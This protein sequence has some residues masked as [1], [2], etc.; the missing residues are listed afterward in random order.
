MLWFSELFVST[1]LQWRSNGPTATRNLFWLLDCQVYGKAS[2]LSFPSWVD[3]FLC[4]VTAYVKL[5]CCWMPWS[6]GHLA[7]TRKRPQTFENGER[8]SRFR[9]FCDRRSVGQPVL[10]RFLLLSDI[11]GLHVEGRPPWREDGSVIYSYNLLSLFDPSPAELVTTSYCIIWDH[12][13]LSHTGLPQPGG[14]GPCIHIPHE[15]GGPVIPPG[16]PFCRLLRLA[17]PFELSWVESSRV[18]FILR[19]TV[20]RTVL[21]GIGLPFGAH[22]QILSLSF[23]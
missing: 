11:C 13:L 19:P 22:N 5:H 2:V 8:L 7:I 18:E 12:M 4:Y 3:R 14:P 6:C 16:F 9:L 17:G 20:N 10:T 1:C 23:L 21:L 15:Q